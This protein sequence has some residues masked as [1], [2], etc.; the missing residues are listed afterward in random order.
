MDRKKDPTLND[1]SQPS[2][3]SSEEVLRAADEIAGV[4]ESEAGIPPPADAMDLQYRISKA[5]SSPVEGVE[6]LVA[7]EESKDDAAEGDDPGTGPY[8]G[9]TVAQLRAAAASKGYATSGSKDD[10]VER[11]R[12]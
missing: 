9:R 4:P 2:V 5:D 3:T 12:G 11:L 1:K 7:L 10:L 8:E 6:E